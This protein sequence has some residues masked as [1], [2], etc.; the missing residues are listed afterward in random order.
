MTF[1]NSFSQ[2]VANIFIAQASMQPYHKQLNG[3]TEWKLN[4]RMDPIRNLG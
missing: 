1:Y 2:G 3:L 4:G